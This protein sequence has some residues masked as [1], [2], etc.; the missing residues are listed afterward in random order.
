[1]SDAFEADTALNNVFDYTQDVYAAYFTLQKQFK[2][3]GVKGGLRAEQTNTLS[4]LVT[5]NETFTND[6][7]SKSFIR[8]GIDVLTQHKARPHSEQDKEIYRIVVKKW[9]EK[10]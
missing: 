8:N 1:M 5:T 6:Y 3:L 2:N 10:K 7:L 4:H 9:N